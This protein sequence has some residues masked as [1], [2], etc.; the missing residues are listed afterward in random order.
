MKKLNAID[1]TAAILLIVGGLNWGLIGFFG[2]NI[3]D[4]IFG[5][6]SFLSRV[7]YAL[8]GISAVYS[9]FIPTKLTSG[10]YVG[11]RTMRGDSN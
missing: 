11:G 6:M 1:W 5:E 7:I 3:V 10:E 9:I 2:I 8:V 4:A